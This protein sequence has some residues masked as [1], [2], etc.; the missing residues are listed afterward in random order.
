MMGRR[1]DWPAI[2]ARLEAIRRN[3]EAQGKP[4]PEAAR[5][6]LEERARKLAQPTAEAESGPEALEMLVFSRAG[7]R[8]GVEPAHVVEVL[9]LTRPTPLPGARP[10]LVGVIHHRGEVRAVFDLRRLLGPQGPGNAGAKPEGCVV[11]VEVRGMSFG[12]LVDDVTG[13]VQVKAPEVSPANAASRDGRVA[14]IRGTTGGMV[15]VVDL[16]ALAQDPRITVNEG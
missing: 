3:L 16:D 7:E 5:R 10:F 1:F 12:L 2:Q 6:I 13:M 4:S 15:S 8:Y 9:P 11:A 14:W